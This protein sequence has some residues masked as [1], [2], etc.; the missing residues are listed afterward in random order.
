MGGMIGCPSG[1]LV[2]VLVGL[3]LHGWIE[4]VCPS[5]ARLHVLVGLCLH[6]WIE[7]VPSRCTVTCFGRPLPTWVD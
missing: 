2:H 6:G 1:A 3:C 7:R 4:R 5:G